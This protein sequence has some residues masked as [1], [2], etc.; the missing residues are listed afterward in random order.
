[1]SLTDKA[2]KEGYQWM[3]KILLDKV[4]PCTGKFHWI[5]HLISNL[6]GRQWL[7]WLPEDS[8]N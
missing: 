8:R 3:N 1:M 6:L 5:Q 4:G 2:C 7:M